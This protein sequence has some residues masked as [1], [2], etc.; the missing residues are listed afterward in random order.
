MSGAAAAADPAAAEEVLLQSYLFLGYPR[1]LDAL[2]LWR[3]KTGRPAPRQAEDDDWQVWRTRGEDVCARVYRGNY[4]RL[5][6]NVRRLH[7]DLERW[8]LTEGYGKVLARPGIALPVRELCVAALLAG[9]GSFRQLHSHLRG[10][11]NVGADVADVGEVV[12]VAC[13]VVPAE[14][15]AAVTKVWDEVRSRWRGE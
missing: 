4:E 14:R 2:A 3:T 9:S 1:A 15:A 10:A 8:M 13:G 7:P 5:R 12:E 6:A 11:L